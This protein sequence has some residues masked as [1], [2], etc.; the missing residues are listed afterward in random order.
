[1]GA[2]ELSASC[3]NPSSDEELDARELKE[4]LRLAIVG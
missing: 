4:L 1:V 2:T 3:M